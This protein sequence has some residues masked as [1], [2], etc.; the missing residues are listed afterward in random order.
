MS[1]FMAIYIS[2]RTTKTSKEVIP[3][4]PPPDLRVPTLSTSSK[5]RNESVAPELVTDI[6]LHFPF[7]SLVPDAPKRINIQITTGISSS[8]VVI[9]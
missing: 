8:C 6:S 4:H 3:T 5:T 7:P 1:S 2:Q 9:F